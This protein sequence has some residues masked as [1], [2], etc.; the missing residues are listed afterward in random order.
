VLFKVDTTDRVKTVRRAYQAA[1]NC[2]D[3]TRSIVNEILFERFGLPPIHIGAGLSMSQALVTL[4]G[5]PGNMQPKAIGHCVWEASKLSDGYNKV[6]VAQAL[7]EVWP[8]VKGGNLRFK[9]L[10]ESLKHNVKGFS[11]TEI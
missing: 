3:V 7:R 9:Q 2:V 5:I 10:P 4:V 1:A 8:S 6:H 11:V